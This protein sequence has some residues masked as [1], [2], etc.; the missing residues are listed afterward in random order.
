[1]ASVIRASGAPG[2]SMISTIVGAVINLIFDPILIFVFNMGAQ[3]AAIATIA[4]QIV[5]AIMCAIYF[6]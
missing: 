6:T 1:M 5:S 3:G 4:G 2:Y